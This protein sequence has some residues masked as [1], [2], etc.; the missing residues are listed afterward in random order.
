MVLTDPLQHK[1]VSVHAIS[2]R[3]RTPNPRPM[4][5]PPCF[6]IGF[7]PLPH[8]FGGYVAIRSRLATFT[9]D[10]KFDHLRA[11]GFGVGRTASLR[12]LKAAA[13]SRSYPPRAVS[14]PAWVFMVSKACPRRSMSI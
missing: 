3:R 5:V 14:M 7:V 10:R 4:A 9:R 1:I 12:A 11:A 8:E 6:P 2:V 13:M